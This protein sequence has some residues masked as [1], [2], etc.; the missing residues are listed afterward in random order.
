MKKLIINKVIYS[1]PSKV[2]KPSIV[3]SRDEFLTRNNC[4]L[5][6]ILEH[7]LAIY[8]L[9]VSKHL[10]IHVIQQAAI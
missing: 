7:L 9:K 8:I 1:I 10:G 6:V 5:I 4:Q 2:H 3:N